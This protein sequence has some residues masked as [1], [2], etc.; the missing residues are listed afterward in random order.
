[1]DSYIVKRVN[2][3]N[4]YRIEELENLAKKVNA[5]VAEAT[6]VGKP[7][8]TNLQL[9]LRTDGVSIL[10]FLNKPVVFSQ[11]IPQAFLDAVA[12]NKDNK[13]VLG[14]MPEPIKY[15]N[16]NDVDLNSTGK[17]KTLGKAQIE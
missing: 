14:N 1:M 5:V 7:A 17:D 2:S 9:K 4:D 10:L 12:A 8:S 11:K 3:R 13:N 16:I 6:T 15:P